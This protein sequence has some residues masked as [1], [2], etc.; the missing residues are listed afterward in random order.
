[1]D[2]RLARD[3]RELKWSEGLIVQDFMAGRPAS[4][5]VIGNGQQARAV[6]VNEQLIGAAWTGA[7]AFRYSGNI[8]PLEPAFPG[9]EEMAEEIV[10]Q[11]RLV[12]SNGVD[13]LL[14]DS[15]P[16]IVEVNPRFQGSLETVEM[17]IGLN[18]FQ[19]HVD[20][21]RGLLPERPETLSS[22]GRAII[23]AQ[24]DMVAPEIAM[25]K[26]TTDVPR[27]GYRIKKGDPLLSLLA[28]GEDR[29]EVLSLLQRRAS[30]LR[31]Q[32]RGNGTG[33]RI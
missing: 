5:S 8:T 13:F 10:S 24:K 15:G 2:C 25:E 31:G 33:D 1:V 28:R 26:W 6:A 20:A 27:P 32:L 30:R 14:T 21:F 19:A 17:A 9:L 3:E 12:G 18:V 22:A 7:E 11:L 23:Y 4:V 29:K 16:V